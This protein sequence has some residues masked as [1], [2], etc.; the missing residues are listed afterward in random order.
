MWWT[1]I[2]AIVAWFLFSFFRDLNE[3][4]NHVKQ[5]GGMRIKYKTLVGWALSGDPKCQI[6]QETKTFIRIGCGS[7]GGSTFIDITQTFGKV[8][9]QWISKS[10]VFGDDKMEWEFKEYEDQ[11]KMIEKIEYD[12]SIRVKGKYSSF[13]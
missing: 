12:V 8:T 2:L 4:G 5:E 9:I 3:Q 13:M 10:P 6:I 7:M 11:N 1:L